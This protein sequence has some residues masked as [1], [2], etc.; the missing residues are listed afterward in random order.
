[1]SCSQT[2]CVW[3]EAGQG[4]GPAFFICYSGLFVQRLWQAVKTSLKLRQPSLLDHSLL[5]S[6]RENQRVGKWGMGPLISAQFFYFH[7]S[8]EL[9]V[10]NSLREECVQLCHFWPS[11]SSSL[12]PSFLP[13]LTANVEAC[14]LNSQLY[15][16]IKLL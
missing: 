16:L 8:Q 5:K 9:R 1:M 7:L 3:V 4:S 2:R 14:S 12:L 6:C 13:S 15:D 10:K 11:L